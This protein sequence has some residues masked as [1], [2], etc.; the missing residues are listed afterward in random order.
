MLVFLNAFLLLNDGN[1][2]AVFA[3]RG[4]DRR[5]PPTGAQSI[6]LCCATICSTLPTIARRL[7]CNV[8][9]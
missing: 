6:F 4:G 1:K 2:L 7:R 3:V 5:V 9:G 8:A